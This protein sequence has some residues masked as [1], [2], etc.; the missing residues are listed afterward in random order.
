MIKTRSF[1]LWIWDSVQVKLTG[2][3]YLIYVG[4]VSIAFK[5]DNDV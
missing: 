4:G 1:P 2:G 3:W 5:V